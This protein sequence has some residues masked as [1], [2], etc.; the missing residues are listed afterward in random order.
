MTPH[1]KGL[2]LTGI[3]GFVLTFDIPVLRLAAGDIWIV[4]FVRSGLGLGVLLLLW[5]AIGLWRG[6]A[7]TLLP[8]RTGIAVAALYGC[9]AIAFIAAVFNTAA[10]NVVFILAF[11]T[12]FAALLG[13]LVLGER[14]HRVTLATMTV[15]I[16]AVALIV[17]DG[18]RTGNYLGDLMALTAAF[19]LATGITITRKSGRD[20]GFAPMTGGLLPVMVAAVML[21]AGDAGASRVEAPWWLIFNGAVLIP[22]SFWLLATGPKYISGPEVAMFFL[23]ETVLAPVWMWMIFQET[24]SPAALAG[25]AILV[26]ALAAH[27]TWQYRRERIRSRQQKASVA[28]TEKAAAQI[29]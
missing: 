15:M 26:T 28:E 21:M 8:G 9:S 20:M 5:G 7:I 25:G 6:R 4:Q 13:W 18:V 10:A 2:L 1:Q 29:A 24:P 27:T 14:P 19:I 23:L 17:G 16:A 12:M 11:N 3:G 22:V